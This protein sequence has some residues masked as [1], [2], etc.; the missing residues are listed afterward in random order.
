MPNPNQK[1]LMVRLL[2]LA[3]ALLLL[4]LLGLWVTRAFNEKIPPGKLPLSKTQMEPGDSTAT[5]EWTETPLVAEAV[6]TV[7]AKHRTLVASKLLERVEKVHAR[8]GGHGESR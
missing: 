4:L 7:R 2:S 6:G 1:R 5:I 3:G 8:A